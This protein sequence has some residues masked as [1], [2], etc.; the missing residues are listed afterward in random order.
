MFTLNILLF[1]YVII[2]FFV[3]AGFDV[4][5]FG[6]TGTWIG[7]PTFDLKESQLIDAYNF[8]CSYFGYNGSSVFLNSPEFTES[9]MYM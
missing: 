5:F 6:Y 3:I 4:Y 1:E 8:L 2:H 9:S 7:D